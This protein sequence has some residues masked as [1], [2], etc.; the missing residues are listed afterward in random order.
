MAKETAGLLPGP[1]HLGAE[2]G[3]LAVELFLYLHKSALK[4]DPPSRVQVALGPER[5]DKSVIE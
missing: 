1:K 5:G 4:I 3:F 2:I